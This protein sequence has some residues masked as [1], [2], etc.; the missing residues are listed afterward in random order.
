MDFPNVDKVVIIHCTD[1]VQIARLVF[2]GLQVVE[3]CN[4]A[5]VIHSVPLLPFQ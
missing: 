2:S 1:V 3:L 4:F 5:P